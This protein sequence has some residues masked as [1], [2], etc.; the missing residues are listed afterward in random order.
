MAKELEYT[1]N[2]GRGG[3]LFRA[4]VARPSPEGGKAK[5]IISGGGIQNV[6]IPH[7]GAAAAR[8]ERQ[9]P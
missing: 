1:F 6:L 8:Y 3:A 5:K 9:C 4:V 2:M 7:M